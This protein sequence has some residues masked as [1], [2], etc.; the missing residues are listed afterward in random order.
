MKKNAFLYSYIRIF[1]C[2][3]AFIYSINAYAIQGIIGWKLIFN[4]AP[5]KST[6]I[7]SANLAYAYANISDW[8]LNGLT[9]PSQPTYVG[10]Y[11]KILNQN[12]WCA[13]VY[14]E[15]IPTPSPVPKKLCADGT[16][17]LADGTCRNQ[18]SIF[19]GYPASFLMTSSNGLKAGDK[20][21]FNGC[22]GTVTSTFANWQRLNDTKKYFMVNGKIDEN[23]M[24]C[25]FN[26]NE[27]DSPPPSSTPMPTPIVTLPP[28]DPRSDCLK[29]G[30]GFGEFNGQ[31]ICISKPSPDSP[32]Q[33]NTQ[34]T[35]EKTNPDGT[36][37]K[38]TTNTT[39][40]DDGSGNLKTNTTKTT[41]TSNGGTRPDGTKCTDP[42]GCTDITGD[43][44]KDQPKDEFCKENPTNEKCKPE[45]N[46]T[47]DCEKFECKSDDPVSCEIA[48][49]NWKAYCEM[50]VDKDNET[51]K[52]GQDAMKGDASTVLSAM[53][54]SGASFKGMV[55]PEPRD[56]F[57][58]RG[59]FQDF[60]VDVYGGN[61]LKIP[62]SRLCDWFDLFGN[63]VLIF[64]SFACIRIVFKD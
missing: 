24:P 12:G 9:S 40:T 49:V 13:P 37:T 48:K 63:L 31:I 55:K 6:C 59:C 51:V 18:C 28:T 34:T 16:E 61:S 2:F 14:G 43:G 8:V 47:A 19:H 58:P 7:E 32:Q 45:R 54:A 1:V 52:S 29:Q 64:A 26:A 44:S 33:T 17:K 21:C 3:L 11:S 22:S 4:N 25:N 27:A 36:K 35:E 30:K 15:I 41:T 57:L 23:P 39:T 62:F 5:V 38:T 20:S 56:N 60:T 50:H 53:T 42:N 10:V 46:I